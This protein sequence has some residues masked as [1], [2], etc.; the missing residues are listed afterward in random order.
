[1]GLAYIAIT[2]HSRRLKM[3]HGLDPKRLQAQMNAI[4]KLNARKS[5]A[6]ILKGI[7]VEILEDGSLDLP[8]EILARLDVVVG[9]IHSNFN[10]S[11]LEQTQRILRAMDNRHLTILAHLTGLL[12]QE[13]E[14][15][16]VDMTRIISAAARNGCFLEL[17]AH[18]DRLDL[19][20]VYCRQ[21]KEEGVLISI[22]SDAHRTTDLCNLR[23]GVSQARLGWLEK[24]DVLNTRTLGELR[25]LL[26][27][28][29]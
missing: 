16:D 5:G 19:T 14:P 11:R 26:G 25:R 10:L 13:R 27:W 8:D 23:F 1:M 22:G 2:D 12:M 24:G 7:E 18:P 4:D 29:K 21:A 9:A 20:D 6:T 15:Y 17:N 3:V 28:R